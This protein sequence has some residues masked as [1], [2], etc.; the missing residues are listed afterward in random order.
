MT[1]GNKEMP[2]GL[3]H[4]VISRATRVSTIGICG[5]LTFARIF[6]KLADMKKIGFRKIEYQRLAAITEE[7]YN[8]L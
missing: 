2:L 7:I 4:V 8:R 3:T 1:L 6:S 5:G